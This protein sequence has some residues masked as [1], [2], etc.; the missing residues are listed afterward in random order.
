MVEY[1]VA[2]NLID[3]EIYFDI[4]QV[5]WAKGTQTEPITDAVIHK[6]HG[7]NIENYVSMGD[8]N[9]GSILWLVIIINFEEVIKNFIHSK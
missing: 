3:V 1:Q 9:E 2:K 6:W 5:S 7:N 8:D 4:L